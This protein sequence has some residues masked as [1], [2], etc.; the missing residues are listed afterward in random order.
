MS[1]IGKKPIA[2][3]QGVKVGFANNIV[4]VEGTKG[5]LSQE[6]DESITVD[7]QEGTI[8]LS[9]PS[10]NKR[11]RAL[12]GLYRSLINNMII[13]VSEGFKKEL[14]IEGV[15]YKAQ[16]KGKM[17]VLDLGFSHQIEFTPPE[18]VTLTVTSPTAIVVEGI[19]RQAV[20]QVAADI[21]KF[22]KPEPYKGKGIRYVGEYVRRK[23]G[24]KVG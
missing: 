3:A 9:R 23:Q 15:G 18:G 1:R 16:L 12:H 4:T 5:K 11:F 24:K 13:G 14:S 22:R 17:L 21:R 19:D 8:S 2:V 7:V 6:I 20:G 10:D